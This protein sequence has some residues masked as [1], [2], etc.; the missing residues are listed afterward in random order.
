MEKADMEIF[1]PPVCSKNK[2]NPTRGVEVRKKVKY[3]HQNPKFG[4]ILEYK[5]RF[6]KSNI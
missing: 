2:E 1:E 3:G 6:R 5:L 4:A